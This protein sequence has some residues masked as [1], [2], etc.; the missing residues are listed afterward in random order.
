ML[1][2]FLVFF[3]TPFSLER[4]F[5]PDPRVP[6]RLIDACRVLRGPSHLRANR[7]M[8]M[9]ASLKTLRSALA[10]PEGGGGGGVRPRIG[11]GVAERNGDGGSNAE[12]IRR[13]GLK[14]IGAISAEHR[15]SLRTLRFYED[16][17]LI[18][19]VRVGTRRLYSAR[20]EVSRP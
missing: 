17:G 19:P 18:S 14:E 20:D 2:I 3:R 6:E 5:F 7:E 13:A 9:Q 10:F 12:G 1:G 15:V 16:R 11:E 8:A 4:D